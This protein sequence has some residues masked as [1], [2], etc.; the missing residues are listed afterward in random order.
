MSSRVSPIYAIDGYKL[1][2]RPQFPANTTKVYGN[3]TPRSNKYAKAPFFKGIE[4]GTPL[5]WAGMQT[6]IA[7]WFLNRFKVGFFDKPVSEVVGQF[8]KSVNAYLGTD[9]DVSVFEALHSVGHMPVRIKAIPEGSTIDMKVPAFTVI[10]TVDEF[11]WLPNFLETL[12]SAELW[13]VATSA[14]TAMNYRLQSE[15]W[16]KMTCA[17][18][19]HVDF[20]C[21]DFAARG[22]MGMDANSLTG[23]GHLMVFSGTDSVFARERFNMDYPMS[24]G[25]F[26]WSVPATEHSVMC[27]GTMEAEEDT[28]NRLLDLYPVGIV[29]VVSD[30]WDFFNV[31]TNILPSLKAK[32]MSRKGKLVIRP[33]SGDPADIICGRPYKDYSNA[34]HLGEVQTHLMRNPGQVGFY[35]GEYYTFKH[36]TEEMVVVPEVEIKGAIQLLW[37]T[38]GGTI[39]AKGYR[40]LDSHIGLIYGDS[41]TLERQLEIFERLADKDFAS[42]NVTLGIGS[43]AYQYVTRDTFGFAMKATWGVVGGEERSIFKDPATDD[44]TK[45]SA[46]GL[47]R[48]FKD[49]AG[50]WKF[51]DS[52]TVEAEAASELPVVYE[53]G[54]VFTETGDVIRARVEA[55][56]KKYLALRVGN[57]SA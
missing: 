50:N 51:E 19:A 29:A 4:G 39:N 36:D 45:K 9:Y 35:Q 31:L 57:I 6:F 7:E 38:F 23:T 37:E 46:R 16:A 41:I 8:Q 20:Q 44:G 21:H 49:E 55:E 30:T 18:N 15:F 3:F 11:F 28:Y 5:L 40:E 27:M 33:D 43:Y 2:H 48:H 13:P 34:T 47:I 42:S 24:A 53:D 56:V 52:V 12:F 22:N 25:Y 17:D 26:G 54:V 14:T 10:N 1:S 32:I